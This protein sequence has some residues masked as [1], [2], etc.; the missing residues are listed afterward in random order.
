MMDCKNC[1]HQISQKYNYKTDK[2]DYYHVN[3]GEYGTWFWEIECKVCGCNK[4]EKK[5]KV[6]DDEDI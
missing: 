4:P 3:K 2:I 5:K 6:M 1:G